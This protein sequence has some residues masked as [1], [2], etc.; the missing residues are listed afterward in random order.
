MAFGGGMI[1]NLQ[2]ILGLIVLIGLAWAFSENRRGWS[3]R[4]V[5]AG[6]AVQLALAAIM[7]SVPVVREAVGAVNGFCHDSSAM[8]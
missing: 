1:E 8:H 6:V 7:L 3:W 5:L 4:L 2:P